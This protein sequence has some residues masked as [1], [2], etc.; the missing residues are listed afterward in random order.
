MK[1]IKSA[2]GEDG[3]QGTGDATSGKGTGIEEDDDDDTDSESKSVASGESDSND[4]QHS[5]SQDDSKIKRKGDND[6][7]SSI[8]TK[9]TK[10]ERNLYILRIAIDEKF[11]PQSIKNLRYAANIVF[12][13]LLLL[14]SKI[15]DIDPLQLF[16]MRYRSHFST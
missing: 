16:T 1:K 12:M 6:G 4:G 10:A 9:Q 7:I 3:G 15:E 2:N 13:I 11:I 14:A 8:T 5:G